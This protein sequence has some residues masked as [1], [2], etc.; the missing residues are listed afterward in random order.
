MS[1]LHDSR[2][3]HTPP[4]DCDASN[5][6]PHSRQTTDGE[7]IDWGHDDVVV[8]KRHPDSVAEC[9]DRLQAGKKLM[10]LHLGAAP[11]SAS[12]TYFGN[13]RSRNIGSASINPARPTIRPS[14]QKQ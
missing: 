3:P 5:R 11:R 2:R 9:L 14:G 10:A 7:A 13:A 1:C 4:V 8:T 6:C 12:S